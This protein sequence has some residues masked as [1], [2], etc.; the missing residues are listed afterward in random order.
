MST[1]DGGRVPE[2][3][4]T[5]D[6]PAAAPERGPV[7]PEGAEVVSGGVREPGGDDTSP[8]GRVG[9]PGSGATMLFGFIGRSPFAV[10]FVGAIGALVAYYGARAIAG[11]ANILVLVFISMFLAVGLNPAVVRLQRW[12]V[13]RGLAVAIVILGV[14]LFFCGGV[15]GLVPALVAQGREFIEN[16]PGYLEELNR[17][18]TLRDLNE[19]YDIVPKLQSAV[20]ADRLTAAAGG[21][22]GGVRLVF[23]TIFNILTVFIL[24]VYFL[25]AFDR[26]RRGAYRLVPA[27]RRPKVQRIGDEI[28]TKVGSYITG[29]LLIAF[30]AGVSTFIFLLIVR[31][32]Y[33]FALAIIVALFDLI[34]QVGAMLGAV[35]VCL[36]GFATSLEVGIACVV[37][38]IL[39]QQLEN[40]VIY[41][42]VMSRT[43]KVTD[44]AAIVSALLGASLLGVVGALIAIPAAA[45]VQLIVR[46]TV[47]ARQ[48]SR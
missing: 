33:A 31:V 40:W 47:I 20:T 34:P 21:L 2:D 46:E 16:L 23:G 44:L 5:P 8:G 43:V 39:Y 19:R 38:F 24:T 42:R 27:S 30:C 35:V 14:V 15:V 13:P 4:Q 9:A 10:G 36:V 1:G 32:P 17:S 12:R 48:E 22:F 41:P 29:A 25:V 3:G 18:R 6:E 37:F 45:A 28:L 7:A 26:L 11:A